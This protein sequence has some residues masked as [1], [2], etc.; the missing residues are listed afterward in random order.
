MPGAELRESS[1]SSA[2]KKLRRV[3]QRRDSVEYTIWL[4][5][6]DRFADDFGV[7]CLERVAKERRADHPVDEERF[8]VGNDLRAERVF[9]APR[10]PIQQGD[11]VR[12]MVRL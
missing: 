7:Y 10:A 8:D 1:S 4:K 12:S 3:D 9:H 6:V 11:R 5:T 2:G